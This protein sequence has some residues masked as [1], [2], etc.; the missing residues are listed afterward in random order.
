MNLPLKYSWRKL[1]WLLEYIFCRAE[2]TFAINSFS[3][4]CRILE[5]IDECACINTITKILLSYSLKYL[6]PLNQSVALFS[7]L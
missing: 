2:I 5:I 3:S 7:P 1:F 4:F 6:A